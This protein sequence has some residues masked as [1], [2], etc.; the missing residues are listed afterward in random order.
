MPSMQALV[1]PL[2]SA[3]RGRYYTS[4]AS[5]CRAPSPDPLGGATMIAMQVL[6]SALPFAR[7]RYHASHASALLAPALR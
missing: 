5:A 1:P 4:N 7:G 2:P 3:A 6:V